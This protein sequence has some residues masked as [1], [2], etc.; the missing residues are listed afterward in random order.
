MNRALGVAVLSACIAACHSD[1]KSPTASNPAPA[2]APTPTPVPTPTPNP[3]AAA[4]GAPLP[5]F[6]DSYGF[7]IK[8]Q[9]E[10]TSDKMILNASPL[11]KNA[12][13]CLA[14]GFGNRSF[15]NT[16]QEHSPGRVP[17]DDYLSGIADTGLPGPNWFQ[18]VQRNGTLVKCGEVGTLCKLKPEN[19]YLVV[20]DGPGSYVACGGEG[21]PGTCGGCTISAKRWVNH[22]NASTVCS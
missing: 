1:A 13:Y 10:P 8:V 16:R 18:D 6:D 20:V 3:F 4:C 22:S 14:A 11:V 15:C 12:A 2:P 19:Q 21:S 5:S 9:I 7:E 17:C